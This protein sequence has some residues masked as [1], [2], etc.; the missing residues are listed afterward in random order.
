[1][2]NRGIGFYEGLPLSHEHV[3]QVKN[4]PL[5]SLEATDL[6]I[7]VTAVSVNP[8]DSKRRQATKKT[9]HFIIQ[10]YDACGVVEKVGDQV[11]DFLVGDSVMYTGTTQRNGAN[12]RYQAVD[13]RLVAK[14]PSAEG[15]WAALPLTSLTAWELLFEK[16]G[17]IA[18][19]NA[20][21]GKL[22]IIN[23]SGGVGAIAS[24]LAQW[25]GLE[26]YGTASPD[27]YEWLMQ[28][29]VTHPLD[30]HFPLYEQAGTIFDYIAVFYDVS[31][32]LEQLVSL[33][34]PFGKIGMI[35]NTREKM[36]LNPFKNM[37]V[38]FYWEYMFAKTDYQMSLASQGAILAE[39]VQL[40]KENQVHSTMTTCLDTGITI[41]NLI[42]ATKLVEKGTPGK[43]VISGGINE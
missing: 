41:P 15:K 5:P 30:Y 29:G 27:N 20:N 28:N 11:T 10:G 38:D 24:Q 23:A 19:E 40:V 33:I 6:L 18:K 13:A 4:I 7:R 9:N 34:R 26:V 36:D 12:Q 17:L 14:I 16:F 42:Q 25:A 8:I 21:Q 35:V 22:L 43:V 2:R 39:I 31:D 3:F 1:M 37:G 32:Y